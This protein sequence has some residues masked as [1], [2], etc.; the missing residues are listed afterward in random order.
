[1][2]DRNISKVQIIWRSYSDVAELRLKVICRDPVE[3]TTRRF[4]KKRN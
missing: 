3:K 2:E 1:M 4:R